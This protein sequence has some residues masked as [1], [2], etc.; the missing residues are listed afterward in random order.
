ML[1]WTR[2]RPQGDEIP[3]PAMARLGAQILPRGRLVS[4]SGPDPERRQQRLWR[5]AE[6]LHRRGCS[7]L[8]LD[9]LSF[10]LDRLLDGEASFLVLSPRSYEAVA[11]LLERLVPIGRPMTIFLDDFAALRP[12]ASQVDG[13]EPVPLKWR[14][15]VRHLARWTGFCWR[16]QCTLVIGRRGYDQG[17]DPVDDHAV[18]RFQ[19]SPTRGSLQ[20]LEFRTLPPGPGWRRLPGD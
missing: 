3:E 2:A 1:D 9:P 17:R 8:W 15:D 6:H 19:V 10:C 12:E 16:Y 11:G 13:T 14:H 20:L 4:V 18:V 7:V 5:W